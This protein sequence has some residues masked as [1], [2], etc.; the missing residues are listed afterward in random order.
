[1]GEARCRRLAGT[2]PSRRNRQATHGMAGP[3][4]RQTAGW[5]APATKQECNDAGTDC[6]YSAT[7]R[8][9]CHYHA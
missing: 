7:L 2:Y 8:N 5:D 9:R 6:D 3:Q 1:M 4:A